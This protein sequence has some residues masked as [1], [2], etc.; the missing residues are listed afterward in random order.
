MKRRAARI[1]LVML[2]LAL[3][4]LGCII[5][6]GGGGGDGG[7]LATQQAYADSQDLTATFGAQVHIAQLTAIAS[8]K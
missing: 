6:G 5:T 4:A 7:Q 2:L 1:M 3:A 8:D